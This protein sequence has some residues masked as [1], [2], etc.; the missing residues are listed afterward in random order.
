ME[1]PLEGG[2]WRVCSGH[3]DFKAGSGLDT[4]VRDRDGSGDS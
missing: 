3:A 1:Q 2:W 4:W